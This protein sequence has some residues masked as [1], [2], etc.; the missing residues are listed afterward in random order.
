MAK[1]QL[2]LKVDNQ[3]L[4]NL[5]EGLH[6]ETEARKDIITFYITNGMDMTSEA[7]QSYNKEYRE[8]FV[9]YSEA[10]TQL[11]DLFI[12]K[13]PELDGRAYTRWNLDFAT[14]NLT[15]DLA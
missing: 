11:E 4:I 3:E 15:V 14:G 13:N 12:K 1:Q 9:Q 7:W 10:K 6:Y 2:L 8:F 5:I